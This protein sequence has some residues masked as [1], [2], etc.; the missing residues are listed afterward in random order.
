MKKLFLLSILFLTLVSCKKTIE[1]DLKDSGPSIVIE[2]NLSNSDPAM[3]RLS[4]SAGFNDNNTFPEVKSA[5]VTITNDKGDQYLLAEIQ[6]GVYTNSLKGIPG[7]SYQLK[8]ITGGKTFTA[9]SL[10]PEPVKLDSI[11]VQKDNLFGKT[12][13]SAIAYYFDLAGLGNC[14][15]FTETVNQKKS[16]EIWVWDDRI[17]D[18]RQ[19]SVPLFQA[20][21]KIRIGDT[22]K[23]EMQSID[24]NVYRYFSSIQNVKTNNAAPANPETNI[25]G[26][27]LGYFSAR[28]SDTKQMVVK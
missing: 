26:G 8:V 13:Y 20:D 19:S 27:A 11:Q 14:Y 7:H 6:P 25:S 28:T 9:V 18:G 15:Q 16:P 2:G 21:S 17:L 10:M 12:V 23:V 1:L 4:M 3:V 24:K 22:V 5:V